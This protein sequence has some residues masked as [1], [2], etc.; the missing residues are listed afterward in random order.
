M[1]LTVSSSSPKTVNDF[2]S[3]QGFTQ[4]ADQILSEKK[5]GSY[6]FDWD[7]NALR[8]RHV[9]HLKQIQK[10][11]DAKCHLIILEA[12]QEKS[13]YRSEDSEIVISNPNAVTLI[14]KD[15]SAKDLSL[16][17]YK[18]AEIQISLPLHK[19]AHPTAFLESFANP[20][21]DTKGKDVFK[22]ILEAQKV[23]K[24]SHLILVDGSTVSTKFCCD[25]AQ[26]PSLKLLEIFKRGATWY[27]Q[28]G[29]EFLS[30]SEGLEEIF[31]DLED[32]TEIITPAFYQ[33]ALKIHG[34]VFKRAMNFLYRLQAQ[35]L[36]SGMQQFQEEIF[37]QEIQL[38]QEALEMLPESIRET[39][40]IGQL[41]TELVQADNMDFNPKR[42]QLIHLMVKYIINPSPGKLITSLAQANSQGLED[43]AL[44][45]IVV[46]EYLRHFFDR[47]ADLEVIDFEPFEVLCQ[48]A[49]LGDLKEVSINYEECN[50]KILEELQLPDLLSAAEVKLLENNSR[51]AVQDLIQDS[52]LDV[53]DNDPYKLFKH[54]MNLLGRFTLEEIRSL[55]PTYHLIL[56]N[57]FVPF[58]EEENQNFSLKEV[59]ETFLNEPS[60]RDL[61]FWLTSR[62][63][64]YH[65][66]PNIINKFLDKDRDSS[67]LVRLFYVSK[68][69]VFL[70]EPFCFYNKDLQ[71]NTD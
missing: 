23:F 1:T 47:M 18:F 65:E 56:T 60:H 4:V 11:E 42:H 55:F 43:K 57:H 36:L 22:L 30:S 52:L 25:K 33:E 71:L 20:L 50:Q 17:D 40:T 27:M 3:N 28:Q 19:D 41:I 37:K 8:N 13:F 15:P 31:F 62:V 10:P 39:I 35:E 9:V 68:F 53:S 2:S 51:K 46:L 24:V 29:A 67:L 64:T 69:F 38:L 59:L 45:I 66:L 34:N 70:E 32:F 44:F 54:L 49:M 63:F 16:I 5:E 61:F 12:L 26:I 21:N 6:Y 7:L 14:F 58:S 48:Q